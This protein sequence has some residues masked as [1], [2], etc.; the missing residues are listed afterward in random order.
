VPLYYGLCKVFFGSSTF[1]V[2]FSGFRGVISKGLA[3]VAT[4]KTT[5]VRHIFLIFSFVGYFLA[6]GT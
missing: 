4:I 1:V 3:S 6:D 2:H 5:V